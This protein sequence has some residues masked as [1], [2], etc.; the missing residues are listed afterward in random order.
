MTKKVTTGA[1]ALDD[2]HLELDKAL[3]NDFGRRL[4]VR[5]TSLDPAQGYTL[6]EQRGTYQTT[7]QATHQ[8]KIA[9]EHPA[10][11]TLNARQ[12]MTTANQFIVE[13]LPD[14]FSAG[15]PKLMTW[16]EPQLRSFWLVPVLLTYPE[17]GVVGEVGVIA[18]DKDRPAVVGQT[19]TEEMETWARQ[20]YEENRD[21]I[22]F[23]FS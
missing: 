12:A 2:T 22:E 14:R 3:P 4:R 23:A 6:H 21:E 8:M 16:K 1:T 11:V 9:P 7:Y 20:I 17:I 10:Q 15:L 5:V 18:V 19:P 13:H